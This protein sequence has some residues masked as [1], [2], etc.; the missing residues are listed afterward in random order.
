MLLIPVRV[1]AN[2]EPV[3]AADEPFQ[4]APHH[5]A[6]ESPCPCCGGPLGAAPIVL[7]VV[8]IPPENRPTGPSPTAACNGAA[9]PVHHAC[10]RRPG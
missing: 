7:V 1:R 9:V 10:A 2:V 4:M 5:P 8:G 3:L 6:Y